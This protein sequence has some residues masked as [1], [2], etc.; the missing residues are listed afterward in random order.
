ML[1]PENEL[2]LL[3]EVDIVDHLRAVDRPDVGNLM[4]LERPDPHVE[5][6]SFLAMKQKFVVMASP[7]SA[8]NAPVTGASGRSA[9]CRARMLL[10]EDG[11]YQRDVSLYAI[12]Q[13]T[14]LRDAIGMRLLLGPHSDLAAGFG[15][16]LRKEFLVIH[17]RQ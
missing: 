9:R 10:S 6:A 17:T 13:P 15:E 11:S 5:L 4:P 8:L 1:R 14:L 12:E 2:A 16:G 3:A 7:T